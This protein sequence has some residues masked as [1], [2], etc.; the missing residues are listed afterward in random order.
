M[1]ESKLKQDQFVF[2]TS[3]DIEVYPTFESM[4]LKPDLLR[5]IYAY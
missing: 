1:V 5:G 2:E 4:K 3:E